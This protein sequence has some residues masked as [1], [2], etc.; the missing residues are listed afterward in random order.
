VC[1]I[2]EKKINKYSVAKYTRVMSY[3]RSP[4]GEGKQKIAEIRGKIREWGRAV[5]AVVDV[6]GGEFCKKS[7]KCSD[8]LKKLAKMGDEW[9]DP[10][11]KMEKFREFRDIWEGVRKIEEEGLLSSQPIEN[12]EKRLQGLIESDIK[13][14]MFYVKNNIDY[15][16]QDMP[17]FSEERFNKLFGLTKNISLDSDLS[18][19]MANLPIR[20]M[21]FQTSF[22]SKKDTGNLGV[23]VA[24]VIIGLIILAAAGFA[25]YYFFV[26]RKEGG[27]WPVVSEFSPRFE[28]RDR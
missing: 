7:K 15:D 13:P 3:P 2:A 14:L 21:L 19:F 6:Y 26:L 22:S 23:V 27:G 9:A 25:A 10:D 1:D 11:A 18:E 12:L 28:A 17:E 8:N 24:V 16:E 5:K 20:E 4:P